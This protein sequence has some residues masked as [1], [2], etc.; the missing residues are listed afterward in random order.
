MPVSDDDLS[1]LIAIARAASKRAILPRFRALASDQV[2]TKMSD[3]D[4]V[5]VADR[6]AEAIMTDEVKALWPDAVVIGEEAVSEGRA[7]RAAIATAER[8][9]VIDPV[10]GTWNFAHGLGVFGVIIAVVENGE[11][12]AGILY[13]PLGD[14]TVHARLAKGAFF[15]RGGTTAPLR[16]AGAKPAAELAGYSGEGLLKAA[17]ARKATPLL[18]GLKRVSAL[19]CSCHEYRMMVQGGADF[20]LTGGLEPWDHAAGELI[21]REAGGHTAMIDGARYEPSMTQG[22][23]LTASSRDTWDEVAPLL[24]QVLS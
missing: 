21:V 23:L 18:A 1:V 20:C 12:V 10:D 11:T 9:V 14:D 2:G 22:S 13:D 19:R 16:T 24:R 3:E 15:S 6:E 4:L 7:D 5:T 17:L 8:T